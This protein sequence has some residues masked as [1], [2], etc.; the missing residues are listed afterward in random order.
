MLAKAGIQGTGGSAAQCPLD[1]RFRGDD[2]EGGLRED[3][4]R[5]ALILILAT[6]I[7][8][9]VM[10]AEG[11]VGQQARDIKALSAEDV[12]DLAAGR[13]MG[14]A[15]AAE[16]NHYPGPAHVLELKDPLGLTQDQVRAVEASFRRMSDAAKPLGAA[17]IDRERA[18]DRGFAERRMSPAALAS[19]TAEIGALQGQLRAVHL[20]AHLEM[21]DLLTDAQVARYD[22]LRGYADGGAPAVAPPSGHQHRHGG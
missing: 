5:T 3:D 8:P 22:A 18:L 13:G 2:D 20:A 21:R 7:S 15:K 14:L 6:V 10:A 9:P 12:A 17:L 16:L 1:P 4:M 11:Y 19:A